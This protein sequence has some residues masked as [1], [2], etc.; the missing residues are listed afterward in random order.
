MP[1]MNRIS[2]NLPVLSTVNLPDAKT[3]S[4][5]SFTGMDYTILLANVERRLTEL[6]ESAD[7][8]SKKAKK[9]DAIRNLRRRA[10]GESEGSW[11]LDTLFAIADA[12]GVPAWDLLRP[13][14]EV[15]QDKQTRELIREIVREE[16]AG[17]K[18]RKVAR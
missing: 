13:Q 5:G 8:I 17:P 16:L 1:D 18:P 3:V 4:S 10:A 11:K 2:V 15:R 14:G 9:G 7:A 12:L 6:G